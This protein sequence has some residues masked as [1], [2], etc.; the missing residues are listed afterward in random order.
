MLRNYTTETDVK[1][2]IPNLDELLFSDADDWTDQK[3]AAETE[4][5]NDLIVNHY[6]NLLLRED[7]LL[8]SSG[9]AITAN[10]TGDTSS[11]DY[12]NRLRFI[13]TVNSFTGDDCNLILQGS[14]DGTDWE[15][16]K[17]IEITAE[18]DS[19]VVISKVMKYFRTKVTI[20]GTTSIDF[21]ASMSETSFDLLFVYK[22]C[23]IIMKC[24]FV[25]SED[26][27]YLRMGEFEK[28]YED[29]LKS[30][31]IFTDVDNNG[32]LEE[33]NNTIISTLK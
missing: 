29:K 3:T 19:S 13:Y 1:R 20:A 25:N 12:L 15:D 33:R 7:L 22:W 17:T 21:S 16:I 2:Y 30:I 4:V 6:D 24:L 11:I 5:I 23:A 8:R 14:M 10:E 27:Y 32:E 9:N 28:L 18:V 26:Q 31:R